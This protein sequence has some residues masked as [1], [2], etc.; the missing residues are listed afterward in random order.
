MTETFLRVSDV[1][2]EIVQSYLHRLTHRIESD[3]I[4]EAWYR[5]T[6]GAGA[7]LPIDD[8]E[9]VA[10]NPVFE[11][12][13]S[14]TEPTSG[15]SQALAEAATDMSGRVRVMADAV[16]D[17]EMTGIDIESGAWRVTDVPRG[18]II[19]TIQQTALSV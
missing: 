3:R 17:G 15:L 6:P 8:G 9:S 18:G 5:V 16:L 14:V 2:D 11:V 10:I 1:A 7:I 4:K 13:I 12:L 19:P